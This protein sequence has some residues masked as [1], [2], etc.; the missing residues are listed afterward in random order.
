RCEHEAVYGA[1]RKV[2]RRVDSEIGAAV[3]YGGLDFLGE[4][5]LATERPDRLV[6][7]TISRR[8]DDDEFDRSVEQ[9]SHM[10]RLPPREL[11]PARRDAKPFH[12]PGDE[13]KDRTGRERRLTDDR[14]SRYRRCP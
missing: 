6:L 7:I 2:L 10:V 4:Y 14:P 13:I 5:A 12:W 9:G 3:E 1:R 11:T 8:V